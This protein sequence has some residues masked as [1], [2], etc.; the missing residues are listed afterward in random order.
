M[1]L[2]VDR[3]VLLLDGE[4]GMCNRLAVF[5]DRRR[6]P[7][8]NLAYRPILSEDGQALITGFP[9]TLQAADSVYLV[10]DGVAFHRSAAAIR[11][12]LHMRWWW[13]MLYP[14]AWLVPRPRRHRLQGNRQES[15]SL[16]QTTRCLPLPHRLI[17]SAHA[18]GHLPIPHRVR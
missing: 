1:I 13:R 12:L 9:P 16:L 6:R 18:P 5:V 4:C 3:D 14:V 7:E 15:P 17:H 10:R 11:I 8:S 2:G